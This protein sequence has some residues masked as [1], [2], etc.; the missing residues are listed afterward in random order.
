MVISG[1]RIREKVA[2]RE[3]TAPNPNQGGAVSGDSLR[4]R[5]STEQMMHDVKTILIAQFFISMQMAF[6]M[7]GIF[8]FIEL[9]ATTIWLGT[10]MKAFLTAW[11]IAFVLSMITSRIAFAIAFKIRSRLPAPAAA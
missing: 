7:T 6:L 4:L 5:P 1:P 8:S 9:G 2:Q 11:P 10:W 3:P